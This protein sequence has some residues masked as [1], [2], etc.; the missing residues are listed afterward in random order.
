MDLTMQMNMELSQ[1]V[2]EIRQKW[3]R[4][5]PK[6]MFKGIMDRQDERLREKLWVLANLVMWKGAKRCRP[7]IRVMGKP[8]PEPMREGHYIWVWDN[9]RSKAQHLWGQTVKS[10]P[11]YTVTY[12]W[13]GTVDDSITPLM[14]ERSTGQPIAATTAPM[15]TPLAYQPSII[16]RNITSI[17][18]STN[19]TGLVR[20]GP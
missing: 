20:Y 5:R 16:Y 8:L 3:P 11:A 18:G 12:H 2:T 13:K 4:S 17:M 15:W 9:L 14:V 10:E 19:S 7:H 6:N 1:T